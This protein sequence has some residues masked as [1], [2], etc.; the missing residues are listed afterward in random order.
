MMHKDTVVVTG[1]A[2]SAYGFGEGHPFGPDRFDAFNRRYLELGLS[3]YVLEAAP[4]PASQEVIERF[5][6]HEY[7]ELV[8][9][10]SLTGD[11]FLDG[12]DTPAFKGSY[13]A[14]ALVVGSVVSAATAIM[15]QQ[16]KRAFI[17]IAGLHHARRNHAAGFC[18]FNDCGVVIETLLN[19]FHLQR[20]AYVD[21][22]AHHGDGV[23][24]GFEDDPRVLFADIHEDGHFLYP[25][26]GLVDETGRGAAAGMKL[27]LPAPPNSRDDIFNVLWEKIESY[28]HRHQPQFIILQAGADSIDGDPITHMRFSPQSHARAA[29]RL[30]AIAD[31]YADGRLLILGG[32][33]YNRDNLA[34]TWNGIL[35]AVIE[36]QE[37]AQRESL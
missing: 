1:E 24:Y 9:S 28:L 18:I 30:C 12:G 29:S 34:H 27:N 20:V 17:P 25:G 19:E 10:R 14:A 8:K 15:Q 2:L 3:R 7:V 26:T 5:H 35:Q 36:H 32:G 37:Q 31:Q 6:T 23:F 11:G 4:S 22:D 21:I 16:C 33:G 13:E